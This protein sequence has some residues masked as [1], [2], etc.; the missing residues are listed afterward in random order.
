MR[1]F[2]D[3]IR[4]ERGTPNVLSLRKYFDDDRS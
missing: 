2:V 3:E 4:Y 1:S